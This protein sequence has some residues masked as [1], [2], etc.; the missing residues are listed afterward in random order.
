MKKKKMM[1]KKKDVEDVDEMHICM[2]HGESARNDATYQLERLQ[3]RRGW[4]GQ[5]LSSLWSASP[6]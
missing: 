6:A 1:L 3:R 2:L 5:S 4:V